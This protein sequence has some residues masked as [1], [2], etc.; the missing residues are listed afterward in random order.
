MKASLPELGEVESQAGR[1]YPGQCAVLSIQIGK[2]LTEAKRRLSHGGFV[3]W[4]ECEVAIPAR[5]RAGVHA[6]VLTERGIKA[7]WLR[8]CRHQHSSCFQLLTFG[9]NSS[10]RYCIA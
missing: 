9:K 2:A 4:T 6:H 3:Q 7:Q 1:S 8:I 10:W 5:G